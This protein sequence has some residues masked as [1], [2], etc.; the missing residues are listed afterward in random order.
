MGFE[1]SLLVFFFLMLIQN[2][3]YLKLLQQV[4]EMWNHSADLNHFV[5]LN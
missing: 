1:L 5:E 3:D 4:V 2:C